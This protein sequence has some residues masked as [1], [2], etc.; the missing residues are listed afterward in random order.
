MRPGYCD[1]DFPA[2][3]NEGF[4]HYLHRLA[5]DRGYIASNVR[6]PSDRK[7][8]KRHGQKGFMERLDSIFGVKR[9]ERQPGE[10]E[11]PVM[12]EDKESA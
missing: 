10:D 12:V 4:M 2:R 6:P 11:E 7:V 1:P 8:P 3:P 9:V 5:Q